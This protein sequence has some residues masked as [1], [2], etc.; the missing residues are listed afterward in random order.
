MHGM[1]VPM[2]FEYRIHFKTFTRSRQVEPP[3]FRLRVQDLTTVVTGAV[4]LDHLVLGSCF[5]S[6]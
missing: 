4:T 5:L 3:I 6:V 2:L 1:D